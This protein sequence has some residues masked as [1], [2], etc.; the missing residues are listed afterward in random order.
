MGP[1]RTGAGGAAADGPDARPRL[2]RDRRG[3]LP[4]R[5]GTDP[6]G[7]AAGGAIRILVALLLSA[8]TVPTGHEDYRRS[9]PAPASTPSDGPGRS[10]HQCLSGGD[11]HECL[12]SG[13]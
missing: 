8:V 2:R 6:R 5:R 7:P 9:H 12:D 10:G 1:P 3:G 13:G 11:N 4:D